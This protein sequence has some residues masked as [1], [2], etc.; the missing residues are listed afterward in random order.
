MWCDILKLFK[1][2]NN[3][4]GL[5]F[6]VH[7][8][9]RLTL[10]L[11]VV[12]ACCT[13]FSLTSLNGGIPPSSNNK[14]GLHLWNSPSCSTTFTLVTF[15]N[16]DCLPR[17]PVAYRGPF[18]NL[19][20]FVEAFT[21]V[22]FMGGAGESQVWSRQQFFSCSLFSNQTVFLNVLALGVLSQTWQ[23]PPLLLLYSFEVSEWPRWS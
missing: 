23:Y 3:E 20:T 12:Y 22:R 21:N 9:C 1:S 10:D 4:S 8:Q 2:F 5:L 13:Y 14:N 16:A 19:N 7:H 15:K 11:R 17:S 18:T 6:L